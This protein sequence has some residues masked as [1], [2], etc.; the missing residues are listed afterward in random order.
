MRVTRAQAIDYGAVHLLPENP[1]SMA[2]LRLLHSWVLP[3]AEVIGR[4]PTPPL[5][6]DLVISEH[7]IRSFAEKT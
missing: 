6:R 1:T 4:L 3:F 5:E 2:Q 7:N